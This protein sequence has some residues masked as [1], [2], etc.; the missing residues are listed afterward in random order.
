MTPLRPRRTDC[1]LPP[2]RQRFPK[3]HGQEHAQ[4][5]TEADQWLGCDGGYGHSASRQI[6]SVGRRH[7][8][9]PPSRRMMSGYGFRAKN[10]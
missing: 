5:A 4:K 1:L 2:W 8:R 10:G 9:P 7:H 6:L 3:R